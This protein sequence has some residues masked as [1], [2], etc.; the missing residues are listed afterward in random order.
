MT[1]KHEHKHDGE[2]SCT[3]CDGLAA[4]K[5]PDQIK[6]EMLASMKDMIANEGVAIHVVDGGNEVSS[7]AFTVGM[8]ELNL[9]E[10]LLIGLSPQNAAN[11]VYDYYKQ[12][13]DGSLSPDVR[14]IETL[15][16]MPVEKCDVVDVDGIAAVNDLCHFANS[17]YEQEGKAVKWQQLVLPDANG[18]FPWHMAFDHERMDHCQPIFGLPESVRDMISL[19]HDDDDD[20]QQ[21]KDF[22]ETVIS[23]TLH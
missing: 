8:T 16:N 3:I 20:E 6:A 23:P 13:K 5:T 9:P 1:D 10:I 21:A 2:H 7:F 18:L 4:G 14:T 22:A 11:G 17:Y 19:M 15:F 12:I